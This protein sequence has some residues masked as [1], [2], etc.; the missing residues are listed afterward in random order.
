MTTDLKDCVDTMDFKAVFAILD[1]DKYNIRL[2]SYSLVT[3]TSYD[4]ET[5]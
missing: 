4:G 3:K 5:M 1:I 2:Q